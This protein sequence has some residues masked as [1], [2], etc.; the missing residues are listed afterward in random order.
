[1]NLS[2]EEA[3]RAMILFLEEFYKRTGSDDVGGLLGSMMILDDGKPADPALWND[4]NS[5][6]KK[7]KDEQDV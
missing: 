2:K 7:I 6:I 4:W 1:M 5:V 3:Y